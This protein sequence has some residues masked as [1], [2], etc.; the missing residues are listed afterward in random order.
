MFVPVADEKCLRQGD[1]LDGVLF[2]RLA[3]SEISLLGKLPLNATQ[4]A[5]PNLSANT[6]SH[7]DDHGWLHAQIPARLSFCAVVS[8]CCDLELRNGRMTMPS[9]VVARL[10]PVPKSIL[11]DEQR[12]ASLRANKDPRN[13]RDPGYLNFFHIANNPNLDNKEWVVDYNQTVSIPGREFEAALQR[14]ILE[15]DDVVRVKFKLKLAVCF[16]RLTA[17]EREAGLENPWA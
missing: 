9:F 16:A 14:K 11:E 7:R 12:L 6:T 1:I 10:I 4:V 5:V 13:G 15:M 17:E 8:H 3:S 2:P